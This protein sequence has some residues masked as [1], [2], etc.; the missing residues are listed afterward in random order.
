MTVVVVVGQ[1]TDPA[2]ND[3]Y[4]LV[5]I[6]I[7]ISAIISS[8]LTGFRCGIGWHTKNKYNMSQSGQATGQDDD[9]GTVLLSGAALNTASASAK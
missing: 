1:S 5:A 2:A 4:L 8:A 9:T 3:H 7:V 6:I